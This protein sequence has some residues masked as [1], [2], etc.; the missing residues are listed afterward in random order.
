MSVAIDLKKTYQPLH[1]ILTLCI[2]TST[3][4]TKLNRLSNGKY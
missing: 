3:V 2:F 4:I 1:R